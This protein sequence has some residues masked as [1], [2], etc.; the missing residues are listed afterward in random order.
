MERIHMAD[1][2]ID[3]LF[4]K[5]V[6]NSLYHVNTLYSSRE[7][8]P[9][10]QDRINQYIST[11][12]NHV[13][14]ENLPDNVVM[15]INKIKSGIVSKN[16]DKV[17]EA[18]AELS[19]LKYEFWFIFRND[20]EKS[21]DFQNINRI[22]AMNKQKLNPGLSPINNVQLGITSI[23]ESSLDIN[24]NSMVMSFLDNG[25]IRLDDPDLL[26]ISGMLEEYRTLQATRETSMMD[27][28]SLRHMLE[29]M[30]FRFLIA[31][32]HYIA[33]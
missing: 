17:N 24:I 22:Y 29:Q 12:I 20:L 9:E 5:R 3:V 2:V 32:N 10:D 16:Y 1:K 30:N 25:K 4:G 15:T 28:S 11:S 31:L 27:T 23:F 7:L 14:S 13:L 18:F 33:E 8:L 6:G 26:G 19:F 21:G